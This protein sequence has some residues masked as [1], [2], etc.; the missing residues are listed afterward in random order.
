MTMT[1]RYF[2]REEVIRELLSMWVDT[3]TIQ[4]VQRMMKH[5][6][7]IERL[8]ERSVFVPPT[9]HLSLKSSRLSATLMNWSDLKKVLLCAA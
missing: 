1:M 6:V 3:T 2:L 5:L 7:M 8:L 9:S 4:M